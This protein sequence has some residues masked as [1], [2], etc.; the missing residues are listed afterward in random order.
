MSQPRIKPRYG[1]LTLDETRSWADHLAA[2]AG[3][4][5]GLYVYDQN[6]RVPCGA[7]TPS[8]ECHFVGSALGNTALDG[9]A[10]ERLTDDISKGD[11]ATELIRY[12]PCHEIDALFSIGD[13][14]LK[15]GVSDLGIG[16]EDETVTYVRQR[17]L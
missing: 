6:R 1:L 17:V 14:V 7:F 3:H 13:H 5:F 9:A 12:I 16:D 4:I 11:L 10:A 15:V 8:S 2:R